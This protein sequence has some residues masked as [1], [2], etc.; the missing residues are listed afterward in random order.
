MWFK[1]QLPY[2]QAS[3]QPRPKELEAWPRICDPRGNKTTDQN[4]KLNNEL[5]QIWKISHVLPSPQFDFQD[6]YKI[7]M[8]IWL[9]TI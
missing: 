7:K 3:E 9:A 8:F 1:D 2:Y 6:S 5:I 4:D